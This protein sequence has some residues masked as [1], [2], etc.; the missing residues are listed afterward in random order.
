MDDE[1]RAARAARQRES[2]AEDKAQKEA[3]KATVE[4]YFGFLQ[5]DYN[6]RIAKVHIW[7]WGKDVTYKS[8][9]LAI[10]VNANLEIYRVE[11][12]FFRLV[13]GEESW[14]LGKRFYHDSLLKSR[15]PEIATQLDALKGLNDEN[16]RA[17]LA[18]LAQGVK[19]HAMDLLSGDLSY[20]DTLWGLRPR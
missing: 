1:K 2:R 10:H 11:L 3:W 12:E 8:P 16:V 5:T 19:D 18:L 13:D 6:F 20:F 15:A 4:G 14:A 17:S 9:V 7:A